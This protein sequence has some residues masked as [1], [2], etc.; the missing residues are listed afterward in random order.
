MPAAGAPNGLKIA[1]AK[2][3]FAQWDGNQNLISTFFF[4]VN[5]LLIVLPY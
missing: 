5:H 1:A 2:A 4:A 3:D